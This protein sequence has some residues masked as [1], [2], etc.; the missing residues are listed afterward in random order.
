MTAN[1]QKQAESRRNKRHADQMFGQ[2]L[3]E[4]VLNWTSE[5]SF[6]FVLVTRLLMDHWNYDLKNLLDWLCQ[7][8]FL[9]VLM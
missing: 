1:K 4:I 8:T 2:K 7:D 5:S 3:M 9:S 6:S